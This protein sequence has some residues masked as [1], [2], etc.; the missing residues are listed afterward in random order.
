MANLWQQGGNLIEDA[1]GNLLECAECPCDDGIDCNACADNTSQD[2]YDI[3]LS[4]ITC[5][6]GTLSGTYRVQRLP[7]SPCTWEYEFPVAVCGVD[8]LR[9]TFANDE[10]IIQ[11]A[12]QDTV[13]QIQWFESGLGLDWNCNLSGHSVPFTLDTLANCDGSASTCV[14][15]AV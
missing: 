12:D 11:L 14:V 4:G 15:T 6:C 8:L 10:I 1:S 2:E 9:M 3:V 13:T 7:D 5:T